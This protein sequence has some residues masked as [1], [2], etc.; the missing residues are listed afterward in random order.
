MNRNLAD[1][2]SKEETSIANYNDLMAAKTKEVEACTQSI[3]DK[4]RKIGEAG[5]EIAE[6]KDDL[7]DT[8]KAFVEDS[9]MQIF[10]K[11]LTGKTVTLDF[12]DSDTIDNVK[13][14]IQ[15]KKGISPNQ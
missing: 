15:V 1:A 4:T 14:K 6:M 9:G 7:S 12:E 10:V 11:T 13:I 5:I 2:T 8:E 3:E